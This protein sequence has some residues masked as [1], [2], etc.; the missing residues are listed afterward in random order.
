M[1]KRV[2]CGG[3]TALDRPAADL[4]YTLPT[5]LLKPCYYWQPR[6]RGY[7]VLIERLGRES[8]DDLKPWNN[9]N[10]P[11][12]MQPGLFFQK[13]GALGSASSNFFLV[14]SPVRFEL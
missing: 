9:L 10:F 3:G 12:V 11:G 6:F 4:R 7:V 13:L 5:N 2:A 8:F 14:L 1:R